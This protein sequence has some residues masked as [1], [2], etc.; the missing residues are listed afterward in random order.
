MPDPLASPSAYQAFIYLLPERYRTIQRS[1]L[2]YVASGSLFGRVE[3]RVF[4]EGDIVLCVQEFLNFELNVIEGYGYEVSDRLSTSKD[5]TRR[6]PANTAAPPM[7]GSTSFTGTTPF[8]IPTIHLWPVP[9]LTTNMCRRIS[10]AT[11]SPRQT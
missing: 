7:L 6:I 1:T 3:G 5:Q 8:R 10:S 11:A 2:V 9:I 4:F